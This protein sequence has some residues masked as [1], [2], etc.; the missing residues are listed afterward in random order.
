M[1]LRN[2]D[3]VYTAE[4]ISSMATTISDLAKIFPA[5]AQIKDEGHVLYVD[6]SLS[7]VVVEAVRR[8]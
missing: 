5:W 3:L 4:F 2:V 1:T 6:Q 8:R 7:P